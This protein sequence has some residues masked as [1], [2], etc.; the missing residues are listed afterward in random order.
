MYD[1]KITRDGTGNVIKACKDS[2]I[3][4]L[5]H[6]SSTIVMMSKN[7][8]LVMLDETMD[9]RDDI[10]GVYSICKKE[11]EILAVEASKN[12]ETLSVCIL[13]PPMIWGNDDTNMTPQIVENANKRLFQW[14]NNGEYD[15]AHVHV[16]NVVHALYVLYEKGKNAEIYFINDGE[17]HT[18]KEFYTDMLNCTGSPLPFMSFNYKCMLCCGICMDGLFCCGQRCV[19]CQCCE[20]PVHSALIRGIG[21]E[22]SINDSKIREELGFED[23]ITIK[24]GMLQIADRYNVDRKSVESGIVCQPKK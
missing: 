14:F 21:T 22:F 15:Y 11:A 8:P 23:Q 19:C 9:Y 18:F 17:K 10:C 24:E 6:L 1:R 16:F 2:G 7:Q 3:P 4:K 20:P 13:R 5:V 12:I